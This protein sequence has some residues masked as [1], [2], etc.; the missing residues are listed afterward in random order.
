[1]KVLIA[2]SPEA[3]VPA[4]SGVNPMVAFFE[5]LGDTQIDL[6]F[7]D[8]A[9]PL[10]EQV[11]D[12][13]II[14]PAVSTI[15]ADIINAAPNLKLIVQAGIGLDTVD[16]DAATKKNVYVANA[17]YGS[18][19]SMGELTL[20]LML[21]LSRKLNEAQKNLREGVFFQPLGPEL[22]GKTLGLVGLGHSARETAKRAKSFDMTVNAVTRSPDKA[23]CPHV[24]S[25]GGLDGLEEKILSE[26]DFVSLHCPLNSETRGMIGYEQLCKMKETAFFINI[27]RAG[28]VDE[29]GLIRALKEGKIAGAGL[30][31]FWEEPLKPDSEWLKLDNVVLTPH[32][33]TATDET[34]VRN[35]IQVAKSVKSIAAGK[36]PEFCVNL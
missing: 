29:G 8:G 11:S 33:A 13:D 15:G 16:I 5:E 23:D 32:I 34:R 14:V 28:L 7:L 1:M 18:A 6:A 31:V 22:G 19:T 35:I 12:V 36:K 27:A 25:L 4:S 2:V 17:P 24:D 10:I 30:D 20:A 26:S 21:M 3:A 9:I